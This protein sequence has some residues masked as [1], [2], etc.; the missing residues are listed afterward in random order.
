MRGCAVMTLPMRGAHCQG[1]STQYPVPNGGWEGSERG[2]VKVH[3]PLSRVGGGD[4]HIGL[5]GTGPLLKRFS[6]SMEEVRSACESIS[7]TWP[8]HVLHEGITTPRTWERSGP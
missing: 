2:E 4:C 6:V 5:C 3:L 8:Q 1:G 7:D